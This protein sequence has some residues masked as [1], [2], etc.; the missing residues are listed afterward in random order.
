MTE[1]DDVEGRFDAVAELA[2]TKL[3][4]NICESDI[5]RVD[6]GGGRVNDT[7]VHEGVCRC[8]RTCLCVY[9]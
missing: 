6:W 4:V 8:A 9:V 3:V 5:L 2:V 7:G 1:T